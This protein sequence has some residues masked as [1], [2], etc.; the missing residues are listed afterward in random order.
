MADR[1]GQEPGEVV[2]WFGREAIPLFYRRYPELFDAHPGTRS[3]VLALNDIIHP[4]VR[5][6]YPGADVPDFD[7]DTRSPTVLHMT[8]RSARR[9][10]TFA[11]GLIEGAA[12][13]YG[14]AVRIRQTACM[15]RG[16]PACVFALEF[17][18]VPDAEVA[19]G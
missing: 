12:L 15:H 8:Y 7:F 3:F 18:P 17:A 2:R 1:L 19:S 10:C 14:D 5:K 16:D 4:E 13:H 11:E 6:L 9:M